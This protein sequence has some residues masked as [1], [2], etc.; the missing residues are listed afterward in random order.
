MEKPEDSARMVLAET[1]G[2]AAAPPL[3]YLA[4]TETKGMVAFSAVR[5]GDH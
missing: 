3:L 2:G 4:A 1:V 5:F